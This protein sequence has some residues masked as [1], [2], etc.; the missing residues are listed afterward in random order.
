MIISIY[1]STRVVES[2]SLGKQDG[3]LPFHQMAD[4]EWLRLKKRLYTCDSTLSFWRVG[5]LRC[6]HHCYSLKIAID[7]KASEDQLTSREHLYFSM[8]ECGWLITQYS[9]VLYYQSV[10]YAFV[11][12]AL[13]ACG[14]GYEKMWIFYILMFLGLSFM[15]ENNYWNYFWKVCFCMLCYP[16]LF[17]PQSENMSFQAILYSQFRWKHLR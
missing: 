4:K 14:A 15:F 13:Y 2:E 8:A 17:S 9:R 1:G 12:S 5:D 7:W 11:V 10:V 16:L 3:C 6:L